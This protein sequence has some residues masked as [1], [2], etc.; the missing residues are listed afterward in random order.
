MSRT[1]T[2]SCPASRSRPASFDVFVDVGQPP[3]VEVVALSAQP[4]PRLA[5]ACEQFENRRLVAQCYPQPVEDPSVVVVG[6]VPLPVTTSTPPR[7]CHFARPSVA[8][9]TSSGGTMAA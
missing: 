3:M 7:R 4:C 1:W 9:A 5:L 6:V 8:G 2:T